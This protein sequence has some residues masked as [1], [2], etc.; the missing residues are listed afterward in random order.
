MLFCV[1]E[2]I[3]LSKVVVNDMP[4]PLR[5]VLKGNKPH[6]ETTLVGHYESWARNGSARFNFSRSWETTRLKGLDG[7]QWG[8]GLSPAKRMIGGCP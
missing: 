2:D 8:L 5:S 4:F 6:I 7:L 1:Y 3:D